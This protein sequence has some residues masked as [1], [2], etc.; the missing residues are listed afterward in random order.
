MPVSTWSSP[1]PPRDHDI[2]YVA[3]VGCG[4]WAAGGGMRRPSDVAAPRRLAPPAS[5]PAAYPR[6][7]AGLAVRGDGAVPGD[8]REPAASPSGRKCTQAGMPFFRRD[9][10]PPGGLR[11]GRRRPDRPL[12]RAFLHEAR[13]E[14]AASGSWRGIAV[15]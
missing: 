13:L 9:L 10:W 3:A 15:R 4:T 7:T 11:S 1:S 6:T 5:A 14:L 12:V 8:G 2:R